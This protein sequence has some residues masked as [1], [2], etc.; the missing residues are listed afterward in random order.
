MSL[1]FN[2]LKRHPAAVDVGH[3]HEPEAREVRQGLTIR[4]LLSS[5]AVILVLA[6]TIFGSGLLAAHAVNSIS[7]APDRLNS[8]EE[9]KTSRFTAFVPEP[10][11][12]MKSVTNDGVH[13]ISDP[14]SV[15]GAGGANRLDSEVAFSP[16]VNDTGDAT[17]N[18]DANSPSTVTASES[19]PPSVLPAH[20]PKTVLTDHSAARME[21]GDSSSALPNPLPH[22][23]ALAGPK[24]SQGFS[25]VE[26]SHAAAATLPKVTSPETSPE[27]SAIEIQRQRRSKAHLK[28]QQ[29]AV[30]ILGA[31][32]AEDFSLSDQLLSDLEAL[33][34]YDHL[35][36]RKLR[37]YWLIRQNHLAEARQL[38]ALVLTTH[39]EDREAGLNMAVIDMLE[40]NRDKA[41]GR[42]LALQD[43]FPE[44]RAIAA[45]LLQLDR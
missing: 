37:A 14:S 36:V 21:S 45:Y 44:E 4:K 15:T 30:K 31:I 26:R 28:T 1:I 2:A 38:L 29:L 10:D 12:N 18:M 41:R 16:P 27:P 24:V 22:V 20:G 7:W 33:N 35:F 40:G 8:A 19:A 23:A 3:G 5:P 9:T 17:D 6:V 13:P 42:L 43:R 25:P 39:P 34:G 11:A 32:H